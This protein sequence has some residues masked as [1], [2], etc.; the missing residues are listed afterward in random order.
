[1]VFDYH[2]LRNSLSVQAIDFIL[3]SLKLLS[4][5]KLRDWRRVERE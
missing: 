4:G 3:Y 5:S 1:M 2:S